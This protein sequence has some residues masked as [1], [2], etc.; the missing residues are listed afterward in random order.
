MTPHLVPVAREPLPQ[1]ETIPN[2]VRQKAD[3]LAAR[4]TRIRGVLTSASC[5]PERRREAKDELVTLSKEALA[6]WS[7]L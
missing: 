3:A 1:Q 5:L 7:L 2:D 4:M 6:L